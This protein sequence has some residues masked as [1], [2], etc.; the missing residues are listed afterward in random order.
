MTTVRSLD[1]TG[2][3]APA[4]STTSDMPQV[5]PKPEP[6]KGAVSDAELAAGGMQVVPKKEGKADAKETDAGDKKSVEDKEAKTDKP[7]K[8]AK[9]DGDDSVDKDADKDTQETP[10]WMKREITKARNREREALKRAEEAEARAKATEERFDRAFK[11]L[12][13][14]AGDEAKTKEITE[15]RPKRTDF[16]DPDKYEASLIKWTTEVAARETQAR[17]ETAERERKEGE[18]KKER[19]TA[20]AEHQK[21]VSAAWEK[22][23]ESAMEKYPDWEEVAMSDKVSISPAMAVAMMEVNRVKGNAG[24]IAYYLGKNPAEAE[25]IAKLEANEDILIEISELSAKLKL[26]PVERKVSQ[27]PKPPKPI[28]GSRETVERADEELPMEEY[29]AK[30]QAQLRSHTN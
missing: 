4:L 13:T 23:K 10:P 27:A 6:P 17:I 12:E 21:K 19:E 16:D 9:P 14:R 3:A 8:G 7:D 1:L 11:A 15:P 20:E 25:R 5:G 22:S 29:A 28:T 26:A 30:R 18:T 24:E 2:A